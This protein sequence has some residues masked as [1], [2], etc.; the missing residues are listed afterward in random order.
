VCT[1]AEPRAR[2]APRRPAN[3]STTRHPT[4][5]RPLA[6]PPAQLHAASH[7]DAAPPPRRAA[8]PRYHPPVRESRRAAVI[9]RPPAAPRPSQVSWI[10]SVDRA[11]AP[12]YLFPPAF[13]QSTNRVRHSSTA[14]TIRFHATYLFNRPGGDQEEANDI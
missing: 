11:W 10:S 14:V 4:A 8:A 12:F 5:A 1:R 13:F 2:G 7:A 6:T 3:R 9:A